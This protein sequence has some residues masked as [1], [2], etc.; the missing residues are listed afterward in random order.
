MSA[1]TK[2]LE[3]Y[4]VSFLNALKS[5]PGYS[6]STYLAYHTDLGYFIDYL[7]RK[8]ERA[9]QFTDF[10]SLHVAQFLESER[11][12][13][14][15]RNT[16]LRRRAALRSFSTF[17][18][19]HKS[20]KV[21]FFDSDAHLINKPIARVQTIQ[22]QQS[23]SSAEVKRLL[24]SL[25]ASPRPRAR[26]DQAILTLLL[27]TGLSVGRLVELDLSDLDQRTD[28]WHIRVTVDQN[29]WLPLT[30]ANESVQ[31][32]LTEGRPELNP[33]L[34]EPALF[35]SQ[36]GKRMSRQSIW[37]VLCYWGKAI[38]LPVTLS[39]RIVRNTAVLNLNRTGRSIVEIKRL[40]GHTN[41]LSTQAL[42][43]RLNAN[44]EEGDSTP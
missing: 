4:V 16:L 6:P 28:R 30:T 15:R 19:Q 34:E 33:V 3:V 10:N 40:F 23:L 31:R 1:E 20:I 8:L 12:K 24:E 25:G 9:P 2:A 11:L 5:H 41:Q 18:N 21:N 17:L 44:I 42:L 39:P 26:R 38:G 7:Q 43:R 14:R 37:Q 22:R 32:Y 36:T 27:E 29:H 35:I 13:G